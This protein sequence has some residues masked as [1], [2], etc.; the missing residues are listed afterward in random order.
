MNLMKN[1]SKKSIIRLL[2]LTL[3][4]VV[5]GSS[6]WAQQAAPPAS[7]GKEYSDA[8]LKQFISANQAMGE[9]QQANEQEMVKVIEDEGLDVQSYNE[10]AAAQQDPE[11]DVSEDKKA[12]FEKVAVKV[13]KIQED[14]REEVQEKMEEIGISMEKY[15]K[16]MM[17][18]QQDTEVREKVNALLN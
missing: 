11:A 10:I 15:Q 9:I 5:L 7:E 16:I 13:N 4:S 12:K 18:Y 2:S 6:A 1:A 17:A 14:M 3:L 8:E